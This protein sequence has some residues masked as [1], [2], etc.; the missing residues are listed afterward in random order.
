MWIN[1][2][3]K[4][5]GTH[6]S[7]KSIFDLFNPITDES[8]IFTR[9][10]LDATGLF[11]TLPTSIPTLDDVGNVDGAGGMSPSFSLSVDS[12]FTS[13]GG[14]LRASFSFDLESLRLPR[15][16]ESLENKSEQDQPLSVGDSSMTPLRQK[17]ERKRRQLDQAGI[18]RD[19]QEMDEYLSLETVAS[20]S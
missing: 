18:P 9:S 20:D 15:P 2:C 14:E 3:K 13:S 7:S 12:N 19:K 11:S 6:Q 5:G 17:I 10:L 16:P 8:V 4:I 1:R